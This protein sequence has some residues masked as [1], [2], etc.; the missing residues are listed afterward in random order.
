M[1]WC[2][3]E[4]PKKSIC[5]APNSAPNVDWQLVYLQ[6]D[7]KGFF[8]EGVQD[9]QVRFQGWNWSSPL[10]S[11]QQN[12]VC[13]AWHSF[14]YPSVRSSQPHITLPP[15]SVDGPL[16]PSDGLFSFLKTNNHEYVYKD[17]SPLLGRIGQSRGWL[18]LKR[19]H[20]RKVPGWW[21][22]ILLDGVPGNN[23]M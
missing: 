5:E 7:S 10:F 4:S 13:C 18:D 23:T 3:T 8:I 17:V 20:T 6:T 19:R 2:L 11:C 1:T 9:Q 12:S 21:E 14:S 22:Q 15:L 16:E